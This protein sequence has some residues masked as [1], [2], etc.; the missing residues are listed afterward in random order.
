MARGYEILAILV[1][2]I[3]VVA[4]IFFAIAVIRNP[5]NVL[6]NL[7]NLGLIFFSSTLGA[8]SLLAFAQTIRLALQIEQNTRQTQEACRQLADHLGAIETEP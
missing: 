6:A 4:M 2:A 1:L 8:L 3:A 7:L 5:N